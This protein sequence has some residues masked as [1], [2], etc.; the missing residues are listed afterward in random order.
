MYS[1]V[2]MWMVGPVHIFCVF[3]VC[4]PVCVCVCVVY[5]CTSLV[6]FLSPA[7]CM[8]VCFS[9]RFSVSINFRPPVLPG[10]EHGAG[11]CDP[12]VP[13]AVYGV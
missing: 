9:A 10:H 8:H 4:F 2:C 7:L 13:L 11:E 3:C 5:L 6:M 12:D 1:C